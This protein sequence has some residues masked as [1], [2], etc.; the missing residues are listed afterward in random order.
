MLKYVKLP[1]PIDAALMKAELQKLE[2]VTF[3]DHYNKPHYEGD[4][5][6]ISLRSPSG[7]A[8]NI[9]SIHASSDHAAN[10]YQDTPLM[11]RCPYIKSVISQLHCEKTMIRLMKLNAGAVIKTH[12]DHDM[13]FESGEARFHIP[14]VTNDQVEFFV[15]EE[16]ITLKEGAC[17]Y[18]N[19]NLPHRVTNGG[20]TD[21]I[22]LVIDCIVNDWVSDQ[23]SN[24]GFL[25]KEIDAPQQQQYSSRQRKLIIAELRRMNTAQSHSL[26]DKM[27]AEHEA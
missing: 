1:L 7:K 27:E 6:V 13:N 18:L 4:W 15:D 26:A 16:R 14:I 19:L 11:D 23:F 5:S 2:G 17:W 22:H 12:T 8:E 21:R 25:R 20:T 10:T 9:V 24:P 3:I